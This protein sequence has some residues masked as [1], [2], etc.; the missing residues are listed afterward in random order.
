MLD[1]KRYFYNR[2]LD[3]WSTAWIGAKPK[4]AN[5]RPIRERPEGV[6]DYWPHGAPPELNAAEIAVGHPTWN[7]DDVIAVDVPF[8]EDP[9]P[10][11]AIEAQTPPPDLRSDR[12]K[13]VE[14]I[15]GKDDA[16]ISPEEVTEVTLYLARQARGVDNTP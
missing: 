10:P 5:G 16:D 8:G 14:V 6:P 3:R 15:L 2:A 12:E 1:S 7:I 4:D 13:S 9:R 11:A